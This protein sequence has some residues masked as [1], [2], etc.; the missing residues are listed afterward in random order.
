MT[1]EST[2]YKC[3]VHVRNG[4]VLADIAHVDHHR[5]CTED[6]PRTVLMFLPCLSEAPM[7]KAW[8]S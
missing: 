7:H 3:T 5:L 2:N 8:G 4:T 6:E 1:E